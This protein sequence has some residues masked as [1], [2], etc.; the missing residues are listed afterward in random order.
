MDKDFMLADQE[1]DKQS[2]RRSMEGGS[3]GIWIT[4]ILFWGG[5]V[6]VIGLSVLNG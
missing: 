1:E 3:L 4:F 2:I 5:T 6:L